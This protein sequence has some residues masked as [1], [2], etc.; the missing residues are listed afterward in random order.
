MTEPNLRFPV[1]FCENLRFFL[2]KSVVSCALQMLEF[3]GERVICENLRFSAKIC[4]LGFLC[5]FSSVPLS[6]VRT[7]FRYRER[8]LNPNIFFSNFS[9]TA[10]ISRQNP[11]ISRQKKFDSLGFEGHTELFGPTPSRGR[12]PPDRKIS[13]LKSLGLCSFSEQLPCR[14]AEV[15]FSS[16][17]LCQRCREIWREILVKF[18]VLR[19]PGFGCTAENFTKISRQKRC[20]KRKISRKFHSAGAQR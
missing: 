20:E 17:F 2:R 10:G 12:P 4:A 13:G 9:G 18:S 19:F 1:V 6:A 3:Q 16:V 14:S 11:R 15:K 5:H 7:T 8:E